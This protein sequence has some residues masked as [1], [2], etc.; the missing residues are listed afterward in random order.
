MLFKPKQAFHVISADGRP[1]GTGLVADP[2]M[3][4]RSG[5]AAMLCVLDV[6]VTEGASNALLCQDQTT[7]SGIEEMFGKM[8]S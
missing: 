7:I 5:S 4:K 8:K 2:V 1:P 3:S 6:L